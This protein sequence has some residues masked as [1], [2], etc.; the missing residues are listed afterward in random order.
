MFCCAPAAH[1][2][3]L[4]LVRDKRLLLWRK[5]PLRGCWLLDKIGGLL[6]PPYYARKSNCLVVLIERSVFLDDWK[7]LVTLQFCRVAFKSSVMSFIPF[8]KHMPH[9][10]TIS[11]VMYIVTHK[12]MVHFLC[13][14][15]PLP[16]WHSYTVC[17]LGLIRGIYS[18]STVQETSIS[19]PLL[20]SVLAP[21]SYQE[22]VGLNPGWRCIYFSY[23][24]LF[25][26]LYL[27][28]SYYEVDEE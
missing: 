21:G 18:I 28:S 20:V 3:H 13:N 12:L 25:V 6:N 23:Y 19:W 7:E 26:R 10:C 27:S 2:M 24:C 22:Y 9:M 1:T 8:L 14:M 15:Q 4:F 5:M 17:P 16:V 11:L